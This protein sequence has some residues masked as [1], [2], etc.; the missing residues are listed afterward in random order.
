MTIRRVLFGVFCAVMAT[1]HVAG[2]AA[3]SDA[4][5]KRVIL[6]L[7][8]GNA[9]SKRKPIRIPHMAEMP[10]NHLGLVVRYHDISLGLPAGAAL[11]GVR[12]V[13]TWFNSD[14]IL[15]DPAGYLRWATGVVETGRRF[16]ILGNFG[17]AGDRKDRPTAR[18]EIDKFF[19]ALGIQF[20]GRV[21]QVTYDVRVSH[22]DPRMVEFE[23]PLDAVLPPFDALRPV[24]PGARSH[25][26]LQWGREATRKQAHL[27]FVTPKG[28]YAAAAYEAVWTEELRQ[29]RIN[30]FEFFRQAFATD[31][32]PKPDTTTLSGRRLYYSHIDGDGWRNV[33]SVEKYTDR[34]TL[35][36][37][38]IL[39]E[40]IEAYPDLP[41]TVAPVV[42]DI[43][44]AWFGTDE[45]LRLA[46]EI[47]GLSQVEAGSHTYSHP[48]F[49]GFFADGNP[50]KE[51]PYLHLYPT[52]GRKRAAIH[53]LYDRDEDTGD[54]K[55]Q[56]YTIPRAYA[57]E[58]FSLEKEIEASVAFIESILP[59][60][61][62][63]KILQWSGDTSPFEEAVS[64]TR[65]IGIAN[66]N[67]GDSRF[68]PAY[69]SYGWVSPIGTQVGGQRQIYASTSN[70]NLYT[71][72][73]TNRYFGFRYLRHTL[74]N[75]E[76]PIRV[77]PFNIYYHMY[78]GEKSASLKA[79]LENLDLARGQALAPVT[80]SHF[81][82][83][84]EGFY[85]TRLVSLGRNR[86]RV[87]NRGELQT[88][89][90]DHADM[91][92]VDFT[93]SRGVIGQNHHQGSLYVSLD[94]AAPA[95]VIALKDYANDGSPP[96]ARR[97]YLVDGRW[98]MRN[99]EI[100]GSGGFTVDARGF[101]RGDLRWKMPQSGSY[102][103]VVDGPK[104]ELR[105]FRADADDNGVL[106]FQAV[107]ESL[108][109]WI[110]DGVRI[111]VKRAPS[112]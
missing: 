36:S 1:L 50:D 49:W 2:V 25:L 56:G 30:P 89:R 16:V 62:K 110:T 85:S 33:S 57:V 70:E 78:S 20:S 7:Y 24:A 75:T 80:A 35:S 39:R 59:T 103:I 28:G 34:R 41:V 84:A 72:L 22:K 3:A 95:P 52:P 68:D 64:A 26:V 97:P 8:D 106:A 15:E 111:T 93:Q 37:E 105:R 112:S 69:P 5:V 32:L 23:R 71:E 29:W 4:P 61:K 104:G 82:K 88:I 102:L 66:I 96:S 44:R 42:G 13:L 54:A 60:G 48:F 107:S 98:R 94:P 83:I 31:D 17:F 65:Q 14:N 77:K 79:L 43:D 67:G 45:S 38:V 55:I 76:T 11:E 9:N 19:R 74:R 63:L 10:L 47:L 73:W 18:V 99:L 53:N 12:G 92:A 100:K 109:P 101:G 21:K 87:E 90:F 46:R 91:R 81:A 108:G 51:K 27:V 6:A 86:W 40:A 58:P